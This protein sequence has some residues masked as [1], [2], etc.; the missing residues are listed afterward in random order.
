[1]SELMVLS[2]LPCMI[3]YRRKKKGDLFHVYCERFQ[4]N[5]LISISDG[6]IVCSVCWGPRVPFIMIKDV[7][8]CLLIM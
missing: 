4:S 6:R 1:M 2:P 7:F 5:Y 3:F 8:K